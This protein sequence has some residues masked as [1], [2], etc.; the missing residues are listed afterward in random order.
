MSGDVAT[1]ESGDNP[2]VR[3]CPRD[4]IGA[5]YV[6]TTVEE[7]VDRGEPLRAVVALLRAGA[8]SESHEDRIEALDEGGLSELGAGGRPAGDEREVQV[9]LVEGLD[10]RDRLPVAVDAVAQ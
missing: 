9:P 5:A 7:P 6:R 10:A 2:R 3:S 1:G 4:G 8:V